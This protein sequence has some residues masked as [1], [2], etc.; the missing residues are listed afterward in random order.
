LYFDGTSFATDG[1]AADVADVVDPPP[2]VD[3]EDVL[4]L[5]L[6]HAAIAP[7]H[8]SEADATNQHLGICM[9]AP[10]PDTRAQDKGHGER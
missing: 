5:L 8:S 1:L 2:E 10:F 6:P 3:D 4:L 9:T 7:A